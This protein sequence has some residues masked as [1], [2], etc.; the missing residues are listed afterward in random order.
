MLASTSTRTCICRWGDVS[1]DLEMSYSIGSTT[2]EGS[3][4]W[5]RIWLRNHFPNKPACSAF[6]GY[7]RCSP[8][9]GAW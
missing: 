2:Q 6:L 5:S 8:P 3:A 1:K 9:Y 7:R 4:G